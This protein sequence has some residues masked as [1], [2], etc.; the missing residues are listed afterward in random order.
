MRRRFSGKHTPKN[1]V[2]KG[3]FGCPFARTLRLCSGQA[4]QERRVE[5]PRRTLRSAAMTVLICP[6]IFLCFSSRM[7]VM[8]EA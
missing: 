7:P 1:F 6:G 8:S 4:P 3:S 2:E 5:E